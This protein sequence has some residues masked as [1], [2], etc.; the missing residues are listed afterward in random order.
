MEKLSL[1]RGGV[2]AGQLIKLYTDTLGSGAAIFVAIAAFITMFSTT[3]TCLDA[4]PRAMSKAHYLLVGQPAIK[5]SPPAKEE[6]EPT[7]V[8]KTYYWGWLLVLII[9]TIIILT[10]FTANMGTFIKVATILSFLTTPFFAIMNTLL[11]TS[12]R[13]PKSSR[14]AAWLQGLSWAGIVFLLVFAGIYIWSLIPA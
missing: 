9:G 8:P 7:A 3:I 14:P 13:I 4:M 6:F 2:F 1:I 11:V 10:V 12:K 5:Q